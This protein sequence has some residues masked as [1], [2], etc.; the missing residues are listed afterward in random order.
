MTIL[1]LPNIAA[2]VCMSANKII[3]ANR[4]FCLKAVGN[5]YLL[6]LIFWEYTLFGLHNRQ[7]FGQRRDEPL[8]VMLSRPTKIFCLLYHGSC[9]NGQVF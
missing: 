5:R 6:L 2:S 3:M 8:Q 4:L 7:K 1:L 9:R